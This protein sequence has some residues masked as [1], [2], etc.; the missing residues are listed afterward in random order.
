MNDNF[1]AKSLKWSAKSV[2]NHINAIFNR[3]AEIY[4]MFISKQ[5]VCGASIKLGIYNYILIFIAEICGDIDSLCLIGVLYSRVKSNCVIL[6]SGEWRG[7][8]I[9]N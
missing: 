1:V 9:L 7:V 5:T 3:Y 4:A 2:E 8:R 6:E